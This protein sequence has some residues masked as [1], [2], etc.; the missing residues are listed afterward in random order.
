MLQIPPF[1]LFF[2]NFFVFFEFFFEAELSIQ[3]MPR[4][5]RGVLFFYFADTDAAR[6]PRGCRADTAADTAA[7]IAP[8]RPMAAPTDQ[9]I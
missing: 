9:Q 7:E 4:G 8:G 5:G 1:F 2:S 6:M 3:D